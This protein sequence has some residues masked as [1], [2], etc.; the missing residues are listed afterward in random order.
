[1]PTNR[2]VSETHSTAAQYMVPLGGWDLPHLP[3]ACC[4]MPGHPV[5]AHITMWG[6]GIHL[7][8]HRLLGIFLWLAFPPQLGFKEADRH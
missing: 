1:M 3:P 5:T 2:Q 6:A 7:Y 8:P 4:G